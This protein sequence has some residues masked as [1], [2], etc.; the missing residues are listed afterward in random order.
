MFLCVPAQYSAR[1]CWIYR[2][3]VVNIGFAVAVQPVGLRQSAVNALQQC[4]ACCTALLVDW[5]PATLLV[6]CYTALL[7]DCYTGG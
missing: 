6:D 7:V 3:A 5:R 1:H 4:E 2:V